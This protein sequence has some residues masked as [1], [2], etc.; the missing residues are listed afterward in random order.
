LSNNINY[1]ASTRFLIKKISLAI[2]AGVSFA[3]IEAQSNDIADAESFEG[4]EPKGNLI[5]TS[6]LGNELKIISLNIQKT[7]NLVRQKA[8]R[9]ARIPEAKDTLILWITS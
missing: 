2:L 7:S 6:A 9:S 5:Q 3:G 1:P 8:H 4:I